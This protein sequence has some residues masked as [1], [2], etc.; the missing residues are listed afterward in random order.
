[1]AFCSGRV[2]AIFISQSLSCNS[3][4]YSSMTFLLIFSILCLI[5]NT[6]SLGSF[7]FF[8]PDSVTSWLNAIGCFD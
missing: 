8:N 2:G 7:V 1:M 6:E 5:N 3:V 4:E